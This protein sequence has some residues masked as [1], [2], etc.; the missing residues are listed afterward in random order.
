MCASNKKYSESVIIYSGFFQVLT[1]LMSVSPPPDRFLLP[2]LK[3][4]QS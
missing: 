2:K 3:I 4:E 1:D